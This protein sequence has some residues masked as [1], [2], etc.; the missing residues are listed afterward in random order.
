M[1][2]ASQLLR[3][4]GQG[5]LEAPDKLVRLL[6]AAK[7]PG[8]VYTN[9]SFS[10]N[11]GQMKAIGYVRVSTEEQGQSGAGL[12]A[13]RQAI[14]KAA[15]Q[16]GWTLGDIYEDVAASGKSMNGRKG[17]NDALKAVEGGKA[18][19][20]VVA[21]LD[22]LSRSLLD[23]STLMERSR[24]KKWAVVALDLNVD[25]TTPA[26]EMMA[27]VL[28]TFAHF[29]RRLIGQRTKDALAVKKAQGVRLGRP[30]T[31][32]ENVRRRIRR[33]HKAGYSLSA[34]AN[35][36]SEEAVP[37]AHGGR[38]WHASTIKAVLKST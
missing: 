1:D 27:N 32:P 31:L 7:S 12:E 9:P 10:V 33:M 11:S 35:Q 5:R 20:L 13:Q 36:L 23:F 34:I 8:L 15:S 37:T 4:V 26:G 19:V 18:D 28:A 24:L 3:A 25:T 29:E 21:K 6:R 16:R 30:Q 38:R 22:R 14:Q 2:P 17:L